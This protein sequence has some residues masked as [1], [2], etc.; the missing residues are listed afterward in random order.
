[1]KN[2]LI[3]FINEK[4]VT[5]KFSYSLLCEIVFMEYE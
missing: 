1:M 2:T 5:S 3:N 4:S